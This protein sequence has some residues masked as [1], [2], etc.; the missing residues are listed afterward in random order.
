MPKYTGFNTPRL[1]QLRRVFGQ[2]CRILLASLSV[3][4]LSSVFSYFI[5][6]HYIISTEN[7]SK[8]VNQ[9]NVD[10]SCDYS[11]QL[12]DLYSKGKEACSI[13]QVE[14]RQLADSIDIET[15]MFMWPDG[16]RRAFEDTFKRL[17]LLSSK[18]YESVM[19]ILNQIPLTSLRARFSMNVKT[20]DGE[21]RA[22]FPQYAKIGC[23]KVLLRLYD[24]LK[25][26]T[27][28]M[29]AILESYEEF[30]PDSNNMPKKRGRKAALYRLAYD[31][32]AGILYINEIT[33]HKC[34]ADS[35]LDKALQQ[36]LKTPGKKITVFGGLRT[37]ISHT[38]IPKPL[39][40]AMFITSR[41]TLRVRPEITV[42]D[43]KKQN[44]DPAEIDSELQQLL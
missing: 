36:A 35:E 6:F 31:E 3:M 39:Q 32:M 34:K 5:Y 10:N 25:T 37:S 21:L 23:M 24:T 13:F 40:K 26:R 18:W 11:T 38:K 19:D 8:I 12:Y 1:S 17:D 41:N 27:E 15:D 4:I 16:A 30:Q 43:L 9:K 2:M 7:R 44:L 14:I 22:L 28:R 20:T 33:V 42:E 29:P